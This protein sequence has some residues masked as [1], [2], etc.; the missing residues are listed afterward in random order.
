[1]HSSDNLNDGYL[2]SGTLL[3]RSINKYG[4]EN[5]IIEILEFV[6]S[7]EELAARE[8]EIVSLQEIAK[9]DCMNLK[10]G[11]NGGFTVEQAKKGRQVTDTILE[12]KYGRDFRSIVGKL[13]FIS[14]S[15]E[16]LQKR[17]EFIS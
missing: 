5:H 3:R 6:N 9:K 13:Y 10:V 16:Q 7:R 1:M 2:G 17:N 12:E 11:G 8:K 4:K 14:S 15:E